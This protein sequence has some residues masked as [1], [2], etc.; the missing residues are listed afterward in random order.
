MKQKW[1]KIGV[2][3][4]ISTGIFGLMGAFTLGW[5]AFGLVGIITAACAIRNKVGE[6][7]KTVSQVIQDFTEDKTM[8]YAIG[9]AIMFFAAWRHFIT[10]GFGHGMETAFWPLVTGL[11]IHFFANK[12]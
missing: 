4:L 6:P 12:D 8:D 5:I 9:G 10:F 2:G 7:T 3:L 11:S 1:Q